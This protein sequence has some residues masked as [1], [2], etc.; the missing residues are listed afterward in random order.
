MTRWLTRFEREAE[1][2]PHAGRCRDRALIYIMAVT[3]LERKDKTLLETL[4]DVQAMKL[5]Y[6]LVDTVGKTQTGKLQHTLANTL[7]EAQ[8]LN[9][10]RNTG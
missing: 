10:W 2:Q 9:I 1:R 5:L 4:G 3:L 7:A 8:I 6:T